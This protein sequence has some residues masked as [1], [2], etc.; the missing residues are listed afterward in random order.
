MHPL[1]SQ[2]PPLTVSTRRS[3]NIGVLVEPGRPGIVV[4]CALGLEGTRI[5]GVPADVAEAATLRKG[6]GKDDHV[7]AKDPLGSCRLG[8]GAF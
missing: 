4:L 3:W 6:G 7:Y 8:V 2:E 1:R 5:S